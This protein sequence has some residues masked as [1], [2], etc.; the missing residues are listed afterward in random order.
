M[1]HRV[2]VIGDRMPREAM[3]ARTLVKLADTLVAEYDVVDV[4]TLV[5]DSLSLIHI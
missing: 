1:T 4:L 2:A 3:L 5:A